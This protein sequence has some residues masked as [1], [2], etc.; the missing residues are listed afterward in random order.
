MIDTFKENWRLLKSRLEEGAVSLMNV[1]EL[2]RVFTECLEFTRILS[3]FLSH[4]YTL[5]AIMAA[6]KLFVS[7][8]S[9]RRTAYA[10]WFC[11]QNRILH[12]TV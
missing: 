1:H 5:W 6:T 7:K 12:R 11:L 3:F 10:R 8:A 9:E 2:R 4:G